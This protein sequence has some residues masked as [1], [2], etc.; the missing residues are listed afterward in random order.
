MSNNPSNIGRVLINPDMPAVASQTSKARVTP[1]TR[2]LIPGVIPGILDSA[3]A[4]ARE[5]RRIDVETAGVPAY[6][7]EYAARNAALLAIQDKFLPLAKA[8]NKAGH[9]R[10]VGHLDYWST[11]RLHVWAAN[12]TRNE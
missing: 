3:R 11:L 1:E 7:P 6:G 2:K 10:T 4:L 5:F 8:L 12:D 9:P